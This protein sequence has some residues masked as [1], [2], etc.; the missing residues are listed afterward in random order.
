MHILL[1]AHFILL[2]MVFV[3]V[4][5]PWGSYTD[6]VREPNYVSKELTVNPGQRLSLQSHTYREEHWVCV[7]GSGTALIGEE[8]KPLSVGSY[9]FVPR[10]TRHR[11]TNN[12]NGLLRVMEVQTGECREDDIVRYADDFGREGTNN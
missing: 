3:T 1:N 4:S 5:K 8:E 10:L 9:V 7:E 12:G 11:I 2:I 6:F